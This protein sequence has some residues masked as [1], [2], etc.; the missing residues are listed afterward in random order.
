MRI[1]AFVFEVGHMPRP[2]E[3]SPR[4]TRS[5]G[6]GNMDENGAIGVRPA[7][8]N[9]SATQIGDALAQLHTNGIDDIHLESRLCETSQ[10]P[11]F[12]KVIPAD[13][14]KIADVPRLPAGH[15]GA[16]VCRPRANPG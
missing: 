5:S 8:V 15:V 3:K 10:A 12:L 16:A 7:L 1:D 2:A 4:D 13:P 9:T 14:F 11:F 6:V